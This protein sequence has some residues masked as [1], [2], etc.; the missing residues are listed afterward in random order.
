MRGRVDWAAGRVR[1]GGIQQFL[2][3]IRRCRRLLLVG[4]GTSYH[5]AVASRQ[6]LEELTQLPVMVD[7]ASDFLDR[8]FNSFII[9][10]TNQVFSLDCNDTASLC[11]IYVTAETLL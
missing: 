4:C 3:D 11:L 6:L 9:R 10:E 8:R 2:P 5:A 7:L 1:L